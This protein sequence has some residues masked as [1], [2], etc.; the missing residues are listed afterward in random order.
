MACRYT[1]LELQLA[2][3][4]ADLAWLER[5]RGHPD[6]DQLADEVRRRW[7]T[8]LDTQA[9]QPRDSW[10]RDLIDAV[11]DELRQTMT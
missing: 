2:L 3:L 10:E 9:N 7:R 5:L 6:R 4:R 11:R 1:E 8:R